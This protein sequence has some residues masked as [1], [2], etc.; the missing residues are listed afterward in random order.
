MVLAGRREIVG[1]STPSDDIEIR[2]LLRAGIQRGDELDQVIVKN[3]APEVH[4]RVRRYLDR[5]VVS[6]Y[7]GV[8]G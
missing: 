1:Y 3:P 4:E 7:R 2:T 5:Q 6:D 8:P